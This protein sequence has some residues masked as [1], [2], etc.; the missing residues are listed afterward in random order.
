MTLFKFHLGTFRQS[1]EKWLELVYVCACVH[2]MQVFSTGRGC[3]L[4]EQGRL[5]VK[6]PHSRTPF[7][8]TLYGIEFTP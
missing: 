7:A 6:I 3:E 8:T 5:D 2:I 1:E 4:V